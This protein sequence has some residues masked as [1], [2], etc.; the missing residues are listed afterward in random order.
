LLVEA[1]RQ[2]NKA[3]YQTPWLNAKCKSY[4]RLEVTFKALVLSLYGDFCNEFH[5]SHG[6]G[7]L[8]HELEEKL[9]PWGIIVAYDGMEV[10]I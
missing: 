2:R 3:T 1:Y 6:G 8:H 10:E 9:N 7:L 5:F 4:E